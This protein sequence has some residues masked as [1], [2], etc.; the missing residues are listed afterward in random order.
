MSRVLKDAVEAEEGDDADEVPVVPCFEVH[1]D[2][3]KLIIQYCEHF[4]FAHKLTKLPIPV[5]EGDKSQWIKDPWELNFL[6]KLDVEQLSKLLMA[7]NYLNISSLFET[8]CATMAWHYK[9]QNFQK[10]KNQLG[11]NDHGPPPM[12]MQA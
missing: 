11:I 8:C 3:L 7:S 2:Q 9:G 12:D 10:V 6:N 1:S 4:K 5:P